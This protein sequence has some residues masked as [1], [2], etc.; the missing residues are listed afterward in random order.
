MGRN[1]FWGEMSHLGRKLGRNV[2][3]GEKS[4]G[5]MSQGE[6]SFGEKR[7]NTVFDCLVAY[8]HFKKSCAQEN[9]LKNTIDKGSLVLRRLAELLTINLRCVFRGFLISRFYVANWAPQRTSDTIGVDR[10]SP[11]AF[12]I[13]QLL[14]VKESRTVSDLFL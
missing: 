13:W 9:D 5:E 10:G 12:G 14:H 6:R 4:Q 1:V 7:Q 2:F 11:G 8:C 3:Q